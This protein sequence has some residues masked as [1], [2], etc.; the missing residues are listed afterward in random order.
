LQRIGVPQSAK[1]AHVQASSQTLTYYKPLAGLHDAVLSDPPRQ[2][3]RRLVAKRY[4]DVKV[5]LAKVMMQY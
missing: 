1:A 2:H 3:T 4:P 5:Q